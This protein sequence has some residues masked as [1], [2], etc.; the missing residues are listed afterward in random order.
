MILAPLMLSAAMTLPAV[1]EP[2]PVCETVLVEENSGDG[3]NFRIHL[4]GSREL[5]VHRLIVDGSAFPEHTTTRKPT[6]FW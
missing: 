1:Q 3:P 4:C 6:V 5:P 2:V